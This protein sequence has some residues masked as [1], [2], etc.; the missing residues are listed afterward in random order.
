MLSPTGAAYHSLG[1]IVTGRC[2]VLFVTVLLRGAKQVAAV[3]MPDLLLVNRDFSDRL[4]SSERAASGVECAHAQ[5]RLRGVIDNA[6]AYSRVTRADR[7]HG[8]A[9]GEQRTTGDR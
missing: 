1:Q 7:K 3:P 9:A 4:E 2:P 6:V 8:G 5:W